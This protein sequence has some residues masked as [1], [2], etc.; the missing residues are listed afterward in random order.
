MPFT[1]E[2][3]G[4]LPVLDNFR[5][6]HAQQFAEAIANP[7]RVY[8]ATDSV[9]HTL[10]IRIR[11]VLTDDEMV[12]VENALEELSYKWA[13]TGAVFRRLRYGEPSF[14]PIGLAQHV[15][16]LEELADEHVQLDAFLQRQARI[17]EKF[18]SSIN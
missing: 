15:E 9:T 1:Y 17:L 12:S 14:V 8:F 4:A 3:C 16:L 2:I 10:V 18:R 11:G 6:T 5:H 7:A 13:R